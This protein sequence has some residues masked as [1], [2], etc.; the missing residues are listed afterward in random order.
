VIILRFL[1]ESVN[2]CLN[3]PIA[4]EKCANTS[5]KKRCAAGGISPFSWYFRDYLIPRGYV[6]ITDRG[7]VGL[8]E[9]A[10]GGE[11]TDQRVRIVRT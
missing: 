7:S 6:E 11:R 5:G 10:N 2:P 3:R 9:T 8:N 4:A 1:F